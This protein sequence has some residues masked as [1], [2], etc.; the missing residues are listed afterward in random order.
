[1]N[2]RF[3]LL[4]APIVLAWTGGFAHAGA[5]CGTSSTAL[6]VAIELTPADVGSTNSNVFS[7]LPTDGPAAFGLS[8][9]DVRAVD[10]DTAPGGGALV[11][12][13][14]LTSEYST[15]GVEMNA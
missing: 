6:A 2:S 9:A 11:A 15:L 14:L 12:G 5:P 3:L 7:T 13:T 4:L 8:G 1:M 10:F